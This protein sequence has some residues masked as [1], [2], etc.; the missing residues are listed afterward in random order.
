MQETKETQVQSLGW[1]DSTK[2][3]NGNPFQYSCLESSMDRGA[4][5]D[6]VCWITKKWDLTE[7][8]N[9]HTDSQ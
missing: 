1:E 5:R 7:R 8:L 3:G 9:T 6:T 2:G 4:Q